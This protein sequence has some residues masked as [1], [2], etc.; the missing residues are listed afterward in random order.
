MSTRQLEDRLEQLSL[1]IGSQIT[2]ALGT[3][4]LQI[5]KTLEEQQGTL[6]EQQIVVSNI[7]EQMK[8]EGE[9]EWEMAMSAGPLMEMDHVARPV[10]SFPDS[11]GDDL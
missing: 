7:V 4:L 6:A 1:S 9:D 2:A 3:Q 10:P 8:P 5:Q 11:A